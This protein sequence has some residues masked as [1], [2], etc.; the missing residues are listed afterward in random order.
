MLEQISKFNWGNRIQTFP[1]T[2]KLAGK[3]VR[4]HTLR[5]QSLNAEIIRVMI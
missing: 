3:V 5:I 1:A 2:S 4:T